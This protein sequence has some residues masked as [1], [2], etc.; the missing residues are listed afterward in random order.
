MKRSLTAVLILI[1]LASMLMLAGCDSKAL[2]YG[3]WVSA[4][5]SFIYAFTEDG[6]GQ[7]TMMGLPLDTTYTYENDILTVKYSDTLNETGKVTF[8][9]DHEFI[10]E[11]EQAD[12]TIRELDLTRKVEE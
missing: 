7:T 4:D 10:W 11:I 6:I 5:E 3:T 9:G 12:G 1:L 8:F 2:L